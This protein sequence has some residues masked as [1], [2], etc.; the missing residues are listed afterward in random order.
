[1]ILWR[2]FWANKRSGFLQHF[3]CLPKKRIILSKNGKTKKLE[4]KWGPRKC[5]YY[6]LYYFD[7][8]FGFMHIKIQSWFPFMVQIYIN[9]HEWLKQQLIKENISFEMYNNS[10]SYIEDI[11]KAQQIADKIVDSKISDKF[12]SMIKKSIIFFQQ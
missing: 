10:F 12:D 1:M 8:D 4:L 3:P 5:K 6:Y 9:G 7:K 2:R 11:D